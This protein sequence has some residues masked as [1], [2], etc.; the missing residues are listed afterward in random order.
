MTSEDGVEVKHCARKRHSGKRRWLGMAWRG[1]AAVP[2]AL[3]MN[4]VYIPYL[5][6]TFWWR[7]TWTGCLEERNSAFLLERAKRLRCH[8]KADCSVT[9]CPEDGA[10]TIPLGAVKASF[11]SSMTLI[12]WQ[13]RIFKINQLKNPGNLVLVFVLEV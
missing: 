2:R 11:V 3:R 13:M 8:C 1:L 4:E 6:M 10:G 5:G 12:S 9:A 7:F